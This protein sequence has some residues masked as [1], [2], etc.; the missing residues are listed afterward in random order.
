MPW[1]T[2]TLMRHGWLLVAVLVALLLISASA[3]AQEPTATPDFPRPIQPGETIFE[4]TGPPVLENGC[5]E[6]LPLRAGDG[7]F[8]RPGV[9]I[10]AEPT[11]SAALV[12]N[13]I[14][15]NR[16]E[17]GRVRDDL[18]SVAATIVDG[19]VCS[20]GF[21]WWRVTGTGNPGWVAEG[22]RPGERGG[23]YWI[24][25]P[26]LAQRGVCESLYD[27]SVGETVTLQNNARIREAPTTL[28]LT[29]TVVP[30]ETPVLIVGGPECVDGFLWWFVRATVVDFTYEGWMAEGQPVDNYYLVPE[31]LPSLEDGTLCAS[32]L[33]FLGAGVRA[34]VDYTDGTPKALRAAPGTESPL[35]FTL[36]NGIPFIVEDGPVCRNNLNWW[37]IRVLSSTPVVGWMAEGSPGIGYWISRIN[38]DEFRFVNPPG[39]GQD[40]DD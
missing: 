16:L 19:P 12:W 20:Q 9:N 37:Q 15:D 40:R 4:R 38:P 11:Q 25:A 33:P 31:D 1:I 29:K 6:P 22:K 7:V 13:T 32:P 28:A 24:I 14:I 27:F 21:N 39:A 3:L 36:V 2:T 10:R 34:F 5:F 18:F 35:L 8:I 23:S 17:D 30:F 26:G